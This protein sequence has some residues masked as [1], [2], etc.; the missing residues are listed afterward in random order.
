VSSQEQY[1]PDASPVLTPAVYLRQAVA[2]LPKTADPGNA[3]L[4]EADEN[5]LAWLGVELQALNA[6]LARAND[7]SHLTTD[8][9]SGALVT[10]VYPDSPAAQAGVQEGWILIRA[11]VEGEPK[12]LEVKVEAYA[13]AEHPF[14]WEQYDQMPEQYFDQM[15]RPWSPAEN[16]LTRALTDLGFGRAFAAEFFHDGKVERKDFKVTQSP[17]HFDSAAKF[18]L[19]T[20]GITVRELTYE[21]RRY[22]QIGV[23]DPGVII[24]K[25]EMGSKAS[26]AGLKPYEL[27]THVNNQPVNNV[28]DFETL[29]KNQQDLR[30]SVKRMAK[31]RQVKVK[32]AGGPTTKPA[33]G[34]PVE[35]SEAK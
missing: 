27:I 17:A 9:Q 29:T 15:P 2:A 11:H 4:P 5:R 20:L 1:S 8:G 22:L 3:P 25:I 31:G 12:P 10:H 35:A 14:P 26:T 7:V 34:K 13:F 16:T 18:K 32:L 23:G 6:E 21:V 30:L 33:K 19:D 24:S 28:K